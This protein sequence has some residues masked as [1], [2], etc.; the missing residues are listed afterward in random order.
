MI[1]SS[2]GQS[3]SFSGTSEWFYSIADQELSASS[4]RNGEERD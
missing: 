2:V 4:L 1:V 3:S